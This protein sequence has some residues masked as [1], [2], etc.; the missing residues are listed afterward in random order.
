MTLP[1][2][3]FSDLFTLFM[4]RL[5]FTLLIP[6]SYRSHT[7]LIHISYRSLCLLYACSIPS[8]YSLYNIGHRERV[9][10]P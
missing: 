2:I 8:L 5:R 1:T 10:K 3:F 6:C 9:G 7:H 4:Y